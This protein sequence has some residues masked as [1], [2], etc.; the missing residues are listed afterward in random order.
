VPSRGIFRLAAVLLLWVAFAPAHAAE[1][2]VVEAERQ[3]DSVEVRARATVA[4]TPALVWEVLTDYDRLAQFIPGILKSAV[5]QR[6]GNRV[7]VEQ[8]G[9]ARFLVFSF[10]IEVRLEVTEG[11][12]DWIVSRAVGGNLRRMSGRYDIMSD[13]G[14]KICSLRYQGAIE[15]SFDLPPLIGVAAMRGMVEEQ[16][17][18]M[19]T[20]IERRAA[21]R[22]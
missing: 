13:A 14:Q 22:K 7:V 18:A 20:E 12:P 16:F 21:A 17:T 11:P 10:P 4:A 3:G 2:V 19:V 1:D 15:P 6:A 5:R 9:E 8:S